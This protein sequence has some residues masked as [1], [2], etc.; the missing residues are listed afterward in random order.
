ML[1][2]S[3]TRDV[4]AEARFC[5][6]CGAAVQPLGGRYRLEERIASGG[7]GTIYRATCL[8]SGDA[9]AIKVLHAGLARSEALAQRF[10]RE[11][12]TLASLRHPH[13][14]RTFDAGETDDGT[15][16]IAM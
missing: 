7:F 8:S 15:L 3:C 4:E 11:G 13:T 16:Y 6:L 1:C 9:L 14:L 2:T 10:R 12:A 5:G